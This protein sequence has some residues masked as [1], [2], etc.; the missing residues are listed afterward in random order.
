MVK[1]FSLMGITFK[2]FQD[3]L[4]RTAPEGVKWIMVSVRISFVMVKG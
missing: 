1:Y 2:H 4:F 3:E